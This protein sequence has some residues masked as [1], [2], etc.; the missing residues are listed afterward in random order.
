M[1]TCGPERPNSRKAA[2]QCR[3]LSYCRFIS[4]HYAFLFSLSLALLDVYL[5]DYWIVGSDRCCCPPL[6]PLRGIAPIVSVAH[7]RRSPNIG[8][9]LWGTSSEGIH[10]FLIL[11]SR[12]PPR[13]GSKCL[14]NPGK[15]ST[16]AEV[17]CAISVLAALSSASVHTNGLSLSKSVRGA[18]ILAKPGMK[19][20]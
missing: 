3:S 1:T 10:A 9:R 11:L 6:V 15:A 12:Y 5:L 20:R 8:L 2:L 19:L 16:G 18:A 14:P 17:R 4:K 7:P 13:P